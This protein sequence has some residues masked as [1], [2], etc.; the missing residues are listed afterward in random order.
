MS[1]GQQPYTSI[2]DPAVI[3]TLLSKVTTY[4]LGSR[5]ETIDAYLML[6]RSKEEKDLLQMETQNTISFYEQ[7]QQIIETALKSSSSGAKCLLHQLLVKVKVLL[8]EVQQT[9]ADSD[10]DVSEYLD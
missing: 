6:L 4:D 3:S 9:H 10:S 5:K 7:K 8:R 1:E 2:L